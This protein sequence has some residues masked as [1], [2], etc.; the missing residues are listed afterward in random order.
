MIRRFLLLIALL[1]SA[2]TTVVAQNE[3]EYEV[4]FK[5]AENDTV[6][7]VGRR[8]TWIVKMSPKE[9][10]RILSDLN[11]GLSNYADNDELRGI[12]KKAGGKT[13]AK[14]KFTFEN[15]STATVIVLDEDNH[16]YVVHHHD[17]RSEWN[18]DEI[19][20]SPNKDFKVSTKSLGG[21]KY[22][23]TI[24]VQTIIKKG[25]TGYGR[26]SIGGDTGYNFDYDDGFEYF[27]ITLGR[28][29]AD[30]REDKTRI[31]L[32]PY[33]ID[34]QTDDTIAYLTP[35][36]YEGSEYHLLQ[37][38][39]KAYDYQHNDSLGK[40]RI[41]TQTKLLRSDTTKVDTTY[42]KPKK[43]ARGKT[44]IRKDANGNDMEDANGN[45]IYEGEIVTEQRITKIETIDTVLTEN[46][47]GFITSIDSLKHIRDEILDKRFI[48]IDTTIVFKKPDK[49]KSYR[50]MVRY[51][52]EDYHH[53]YFKNE[54]GGTCLHVRPFKFLQISNSGIDMDLDP[55]K[56]YQETEE[57]RQNQ[58]NN[59]DMSFEHG[60]TTLIE[61]SAYFVTIAN[62][63]QDFSDIRSTGGDITGG[64]L[65]A[66]ASPDGSEATNRRLA[67]GRAQVARSKI[68]GQINKVQ[69]KAEIDTWDNTAKLLEEEGLLEEAAFVRQCIEEGKGVREVVG[70]KVATYPGYRERI[71]PTLERQCRIKF[72]YEFFANKK[73]KP[74]EAL[75]LYLANPDRKFFNGD[76]F[77]II[78]LLTDSLERDKATRIAYN[79]VV[80]RD[81]DIESR[82]APYLINRMAYLKIKA[83]EPDTN[84]LKPLLDF[85]F[86]NWSFDQTKSGSDIVFNRP[87]A[88][89]NQAVAYYMF[90]QV[91][92]AKELGSRVKKAYPD[93]KEAVNLMH[94]INFKDLV[95]I[96]ADRRT[97]QQ[98]DELDAALEL[99]SSSG[100]DNTAVLYTEFRNLD[101]L[102]S[103]WDF[104]HLMSDEDPKKWYLMALLWA[105]R[106]G[107][108]ST[109]KLPV[110]EDS[111]S[112]GDEEVKVD[113]IPYYMAYFQ[114]AFDLDKSKERTFLRYYF[115]EGWIKEDMREKR[116]HAYKLDRIPAYR[117]L[118]RLRKIEDDKYLAK[119]QKRIANGG[120]P[121]EKPME[122][123][124]SE[125]EE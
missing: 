66:Y 7:E 46:R 70:R 107:Q 77:N 86:R 100:K 24:K 40:S 59:L 62:L 91:Q 122:E 101:K 29:P 34:C 35:A 44:I 79:R 31:I 6:K 72:K 21:N 113:G 67:E 36:V 51:V 22:K 71:K 74:Q 38:K 92:K 94:F 61:D 28:L 47:P 114:R 81:Q 119:L 87:E 68:P 37:D 85:S 54:Y 8:V 64:T 5:V 106:D 102:D 3:Y 52:M 55:D 10:E 1:L 110:D 12:L 89:L 65:T 88:V 33:A 111:V 9:A 45:P 15:M 13:S 25:G 78:S 75:D 60:K 116:N 41:M 76:Y 48:R 20:D 19:K 42:F 18:G 98:Q 30:I 90:D 49:K 27:N 115:D 120:K 124:E 112:Y 93:M 32:L 103:A 109:Y 105:T 69:I 123:D 73:L 2:T 117:K 17:G 14:G 104:V 108:E 16:I 97:R 53:P 83:G 58:E 80:V 50:G 84:L 63:A 26:S 125:E 96:P 39:R 11:K 118:F 99:L 56:F 57:G 23:Y 4:L 95:R 43:D 121:G 82:F